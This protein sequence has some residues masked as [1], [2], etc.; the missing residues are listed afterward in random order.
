MNSKQLSGH[1]V[2]TYQAIRI[3]LA[4]VA[5]LFPPW[6]VI[7]GKMFANLDWQESM[8][9]YYHAS[10][11][12]QKDTA[13]APQEP[14]HP[15]QG[16]MRNWFVGLLFGVSIILYLYKGFTWL[17][18]W[19]LN[20]AGVMGLGVALFPMPWGKE[21]PGIQLNFLGLGF[22]LHG[23]C[24]VTLFICIAYVCIYRAPDT[25]QLIKN[26]AR[27]ERYRKRY[28][29]LGHLVWGFPVIAWVLS[30]TL[31]K[32]RSLVF[33]AEMLGVWIFAAYWWVK[34]LEIGETNADQK[35]MREQ[36]NVPNHSAA[37]FSKAIPIT[38]RPTGPL[39]H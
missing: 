25:L 7:G 23:V 39:G 9:A 30:S 4:I 14:T 10:E 18:N 6:L 11:L 1:I 21:F 28:R 38:E 32:H 36:L 5:F 16:T 31:T 22:T 27:K 8:S 3:G 35:A 34:S 2:A 20:I 19:P 26:E 33:V 29:L 24:A 15:G 13:T 17:E 37:D 12:S